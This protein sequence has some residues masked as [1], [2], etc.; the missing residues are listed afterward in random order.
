[1]RSPDQAPLSIA[2]SALGELK[3]L[4]RADQAFRRTVGQGVAAEAVTNLEQA[5]RSTAM[6]GG[7]D[8][9]HALMEGRAATVNKF[10]TI[11]VL[12]QLKTEPV[13]VFEQATH[14]K[15]AGIAQLRQVARVAPREM[16]QI[17][18]A[19]LED[20]FQKASAEGGFDVTKSLLNRWQ[21]LGPETK[22]LLFRDPAHI[23]DLDNFFLLAKKMAE[24]PNPSGS[25]LTILKGGE[26]L[27]TGAE[28]LTGSLGL[29]TA[30]TLSAPLV[31][32]LLLSPA[33]TRFLL[34]GLRL[35]VSATMAQAAWRARLGTLL[36][37]LQAAPAAA[38]GPESPGP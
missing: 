5:V 37:Q 4:A 27:K 7:P 8:V 34:Q 29:G 24:K 19:Y 22:Q 11:D 12:D 25:G 6:Q 18:R 3:S 36:G 35:P 28:V 9:F 38:A 15:D 32:K 31:A 26:L 2:D 10:K 1:M 23:R 16:A 20:L 17:G 33:T 30:A 21:N 14:A 13:K